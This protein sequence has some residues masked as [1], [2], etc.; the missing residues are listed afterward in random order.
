MNQKIKHTRKTYMALA[1][2]F[3]LLGFGLLFLPERENKKEMKPEQLLVQ[4]TDNS[5]LVTTDEIAKKLVNNDPSIIL[6]DVRK[7]EEYNSGTLRG[8]LNVPLQDILGEESLKIFNRKAYDKVIFS[9]SDLYADQAWILLSRNQVQ[10][11]YILK[12]GLNEWVRTIIDPLPPGEGA[13]SEDIDL[14]NFRRA[15]SQYFTGQSKAFEFEDIEHVPASEKSNSSKV[16]KPKSQPLLP[17]PPAA[18]EEEE[19]C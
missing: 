6:I 9:N 13:P 11:T 5:R 16:S 10:R 17:P 1:A 14:Y 7:K 19:G 12:G 3:V 4:L 2:V 8:A 18:V 15:A